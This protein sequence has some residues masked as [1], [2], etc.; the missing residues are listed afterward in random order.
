MH[1]FIID[2]YRTKYYYNLL[3]KVLFSILYVCTFVR[4]VCVLHLERERKKDRWRER[5]REEEEGDREAGTEKD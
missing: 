3:L 4:D 1:Y 2:F 5:E